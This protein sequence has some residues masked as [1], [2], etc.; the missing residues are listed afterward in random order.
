[1]VKD[2][3]LSSTNAVMDAVLVSSIFSLALWVQ[4]RSISLL[5]SA[6][7]HIFH[8]LEPSIG[9]WSSTG[10]GQGELRAISEAQLTCAVVWS[11]WI[12]LVDGNITWCPSFLFIERVFTKTALKFIVD[13]L[14]PAQVLLVVLVSSIVV[15]FH[16]FIIFH[17]VN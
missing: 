17:E 10:E 2:A 13:P 9:C 3:Q 7:F 1:M 16:L 11:K 15:D 8:S 14:V 12:K 4:T 6:V 5:C